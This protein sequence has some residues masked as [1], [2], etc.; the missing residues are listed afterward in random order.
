[1]NCPIC[2]RETEGDLLWC[3]DC[4]DSNDD[5]I[6]H[7]EEEVAEWAANRAREFEKE[8]TKVLVDEIE[9]LKKLVGEV[10]EVSAEPPTQNSKI[11][12]RTDTEE[13]RAYWESIDNSSEIVASWPEWKK[14]W[15]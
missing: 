15:R 3:G 6:T 12:R 5:L 11:V 14:G 4:S 2:N 7:F 8:K 9:R 1:M 10:E 13:A